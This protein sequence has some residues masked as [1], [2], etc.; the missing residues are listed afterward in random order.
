MKSSA[1]FSSSTVWVS[2]R[3][4]LPELCLRGLCVVVQV[5]VRHHRPCHHL[6]SGLCLWRLCVE[7]QGLGHHRRLRYPRLVLELCLS[8]LFDEE[9]ISD[10]RRHRQIHHPRP[11]S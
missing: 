7:E 6:P 9:Q 8:P 5:W 1:V 11:V 3:H 10:H 2:H 4:L